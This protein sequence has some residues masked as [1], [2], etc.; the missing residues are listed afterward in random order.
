[1]KPSAN[2]GVLKPDQDVLKEAVTKAGKTEET[3]V[4]KTPR[5]KQAPPPAPAPARGKV[6]EH[7][8]KKGEKPQPQNEKVRTTATSEPLKIE[9][10]KP[11][12]LLGSEC[13]MCGAE[14]EIAIW[15]RDG[16]DRSIV[17]V[18]NRAKL[19]SFEKN[20]VQ[21]RSDSAAKGVAEVKKE[22]VLVSRQ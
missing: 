1:M 3:L 6:Q 18:V 21:E 11:A 20:L 10:P 17:K 15:T 4:D 16:T 19:K 7:T 13:Y 5:A 9:E 12:M 2:S 22:R 14:D 8:T